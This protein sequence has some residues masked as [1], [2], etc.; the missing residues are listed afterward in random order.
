MTVTA[1]AKVT[2][3]NRSDEVE[4]LLKKHGLKPGHGPNSY[5][6]VTGLPVTAFDQERS[7]RN[8]ARLGAPIQDDLADQYALDME[9]GDTFPPGIAWRNEQTGLLELCDGNHRLEGAIRTRRAWDVYLIECA[10]ETRVLITL[11]ANLRHGRAASIEDKIHHALYAIDNG[12]TIKRAALTFHVEEKDVRGAVVDQRASRRADDCGIPPMSWTGLKQGHRRRLANVQNDNVFREAVLLVSEARLAQGQCNA[13]IRDI[14]QG[15]ANEA[16]QL[17]VVARWRDELTELMAVK[18]IGGTEGRAMARRQG[19]RHKVRLALGFV[20][21]FPDD[22]ATTVADIP[23]GELPDIL[24]KVDHALER[25][26][27][28][29]KALAD[30]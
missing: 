12:M 14:N 7:L 2:D 18:A 13:L 29:R 27:A 23:A 1:I 5:T 28:L 20:E 15:P 25:M 24:T 11:E 17:A 26:T 19:P 10:M 4:S 6:L 22:P 21:A 8:Q 9:N 16:A 30:A 3:R